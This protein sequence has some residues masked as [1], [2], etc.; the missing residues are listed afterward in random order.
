MLARP[1]APKGAGPRQTW[2]RPRQYGQLCAEQVEVRY[3]RTQPPGAR[4]SAQA[5]Q[6]REEGRRALPGS[7][8]TRERRGHTRQQPA[9]AARLVKWRSHRRFELKRGKSL[10][11]W[12][13]EKNFLQ[14]IGERLSSILL[15]LVGADVGCKSTF[16]DLLCFSWCVCR[17]GGRL[18]ATGSRHNVRRLVT[19][20]A[21][22]RAA[23]LSHSWPTQ[24]MRVDSSRDPR[25]DSFA[26]NSRQPHNS[27]PGSEL[28]RLGSHRGRCVCLALP[29]PGRV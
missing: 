21:R 5:S 26:Y 6:R 12:N 7:P 27:R 14:E 15:E 10:W 19:T 23:H 24:A 22:A 18:G 3:G 17:C 9:A 8:R 13:V 1:Q 2:A 25:V 16:L 29:L 4:C 11:V 28:T 20:R